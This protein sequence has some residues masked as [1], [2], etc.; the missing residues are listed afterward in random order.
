MQSWGRAW[1]VS[2]RLQAPAITGGKA[3]VT[4]SPAQSP[5]EGT[6]LC[7]SGPRPPPSHMSNFQSASRSSVVGLTGTRRVP[8][9]LLSLPRR[10]HSGRLPASTGRAPHLGGGGWGS[11]SRHRMRAPPRR[12]TLLPSK[13]KQQFHTIFRYIFIPSQFSSLWT[14]FFFGGLCT[15]CH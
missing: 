7:G 15:L 5:T 14:A 8:A 13:Q 9:C 3:K 6:W 4:H 12:P 1:T 11:G 10:R 2:Y